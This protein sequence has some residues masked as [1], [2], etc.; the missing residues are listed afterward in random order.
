MSNLL[1]EV[2]PTAKNWGP[3]FGPNEPKSD[4]KL[5]FLSFFKVGFISFPGN[6]IDDSLEHSLATSRGKTIEKI[7]RAPNWVRN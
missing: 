7:S 1:V 5:G 4:P 2:K 3:K 6:C